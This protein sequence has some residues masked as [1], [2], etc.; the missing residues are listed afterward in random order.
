MSQRLI[1]NLME[2]GALVSSAG[3]IFI[4]HAPADAAHAKA[5]YAHLAA[6]RQ[7]GGVLFLAEFSI[8]AGDTT[9]TVLESALDAADLFVP[10]IS[11]SYLNEEDCIGQAARVLAR[12]RAGAAVRVMPVYVSSCMY[13][14]CRPDPAGFALGDL[15]FAGPYDAD[16]NRST[17]LAASEKSAAWDAI[18]RRLMQAARPPMHGPLGQPDQ[19]PLVADQDFASI[20]AWCDRS[21][22]LD[23]LDDFLA[24]PVAPKKGLLCLFDHVENRPG[25]LMQRV[26][27]EL[28]EAPRN[29]KV[30]PLAT[31][32]DHGFKNPVAFGKN[33]RM[34]AKVATDAHLIEQADA[35]GN[36]ILLCWHYVECTDWDAANATDFFHVAAQWLAGLPQGK[37]RV[38]L[39]LALRHKDRPRSLWQNLLRRPTPLEHVLSGWEGA[40]KAFKC[41][42]DLSF[43][44]LCIGGGPLVLPDYTHDDFCHWLDH[45]SQE[46]WLDSRM[47]AALKD[48]AA[49]F[50]EGRSRFASMLKLLEKYH[51][52]RSLS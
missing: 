4:S 50:P 10:L 7:A 18:V 9:A 16:G 28:G 14:A 1:V 13:E 25:E 45:A 29:R 32:R 42:A 8:E 36:E 33:L 35:V 38:V 15:K 5:L 41:H 22:I 39:V 6:F 2:P 46:K 47:I 21:V 30:M 20:L 48:E 3:S 26:A 52:S 40:R 23:Q 12:M 19:L 37:V 11:V 27:A 51:T 44:D 31:L 49:N 24:H 43:D 17:I 34:P